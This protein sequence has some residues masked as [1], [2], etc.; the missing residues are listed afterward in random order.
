[1][2]MRTWYKKTKDFVLRHEERLGSVAFIIGFILDIFTLGRVDRIFDNLVLISYFFLAAIGIILI[3]FYWGGRIKNN[4]FERIVLWI[5]FII[6]FAF[7]GLLSGLVVFYGKSASWFFSWPFMLLLL[8]IFVGNERFR[9]RYTRLVFQVTF[10]YL[11]L[12]LLLIFYVPMLV[13]KMGNFVFLMSG[14][15]S[16]LIIALFLKIIEKG[17][18][19]Q[20]RQLVLNISSGIGAVFISLNILYF[21][22]IIPPL[23]LSLKEIG[24]YQSV[25]YSFGEYK[26]ENLS[27]VS[28]RF[29][30]RERFYINDNRAFFAYSA[31]FAPTRLSTKVVHEWSKYSETKGRWEIYASVP[32]EIKG[33]RDEGYRGFT[34]KSNI[35]PGLW[36]VRVRTMGGQ[37]L[38]NKT[39]EV[40]LD[41]SPR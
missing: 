25:T 38:G 15:L 35:T 12:F 7:G 20:V 5:P 32:Y 27:Q 8:G 39:F 6:Q 22:N 16:L 21:T 31:I 10:L 41:S 36:R 34:M 17:R 14:V 2:N 40:L 9:S 23:P 3:N 30:F 13:G 37:V 4:F 26:F 18:P 24:L 19:T 11:I 1:M 28:C 29:C 33:G